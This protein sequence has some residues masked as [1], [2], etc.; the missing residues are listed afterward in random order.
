MNK[1]YNFVDD[2]DS[3]PYLSINSENILFIAEEKFAETIL[4]KEP[5]FQ[6]YTATLPNTSGTTQSEFPKVNN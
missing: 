5:P 2:E 4:V 1:S 6:S 3:I